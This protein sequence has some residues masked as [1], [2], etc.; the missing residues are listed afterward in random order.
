MADLAM[1]RMAKRSFY[2]K[3]EALVADKLLD[4]A[5]P[6][7]GTADPFAVIDAKV[8]SLQDLA[9]GDV[10][11]VM[12]NYTFVNFKKHPTVKERMRNTGIAPMQGGDPR[13][14]TAEQ[15]AAIFGVKEVLIG[16][17]DIWYTAQDNVDKN[18]V[19]L[20][21]LPNGTVDPSEEC[22]LGRL[23]YFAWDSDTRHFIMES[24]HD[25][26]ADAEVVD[27]KGHIDLITLNA[28]LAI[29]IQLPD[30]S[31]YTTVGT[32]GQVQVLNYDGVTY[33]WVA[34]ASWDDPTTGAAAGKVLKKPSTGTQLTWAD[35]TGVYAAAPSGYAL[36]S[37]GTKAVFTAISGL[38]W[39][40]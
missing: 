6:V 13:Y 34:P 27:A 40:A 31:A 38:T 21:V 30:P 8:S 35:G 33:S 25:D 18:N 19:A 16:S 9:K 37:N 17:D 14:I 1:G 7:D 23:V 32:S 24:Y 39:K 29:T 5:S 20:V 11:L 4:V 28:E 36:V 22:Q 26:N 12:S 2:N 15:M 3:V 10:V